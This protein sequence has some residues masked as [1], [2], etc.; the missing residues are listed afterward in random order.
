MMDIFCIQ[1]GKTLQGAVEISGSKN[2]SLPL[3]CCSLLTD[4][5]VTLTNVP[6]LRDVQTL[7]ELLMQH[8]VQVKH[9]VSAHQLILQAK[10]ITST[11][12]PYDIV[13]KMRASYYVLG[14]LLA[15]QGEV[16]L[17]LPGGCVIGARPMDLHL[18]AI[19]K[20]GAVV[21]LEKG[22]VFAQAP[23]GGLKGAKILFPK[24]SVGATIQAVMAA[25]LAKG[26]TVIE[27]AA[28]EP[29]VDDVANLLNKMG[30][31][32]S[33][34]GTATL[35]IEGVSSLKGAT[36][37][38]MTDRIEAPTYAIA[39]A[40]T[41]GRVELIHADLATAE[42]SFEKLHD[43]GVMVSATEKGILIDAQKA[44][45]K[46][47]DIE[48]EPY[49][50]FPT[51]VQA[52]F[53]ALMSLASG[54]SVISETIFENRFMHVSE[55]QRLGADIS[56]RDHSTAIVR[57]VKELT[58]AEVMAS[59]LRAGA[60]LILAGLAAKGETI[61]QRIYHIDRGYENLETKLQGLGAD[62][63]REK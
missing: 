37:Q 11:T 57:G 4:Q 47:L 60:S 28:R 12:A 50:G 21:H 9:D 7:S 30:A 56:I 25:V 3:M 41:H 1:G 5:L 33:G 40:I 36:H 23:A 44:E 45:I 51:D 10:E 18:M 2:A 58:G 62:I 38:V 46:G 16:H 26:T 52:Q 53:M 22:Y 34:I 48:T 31:Q 29:D 17:S 8:G 32:I 61:V 63:R 35:V 39:A 24:V 54:T 14:P 27:N 15:R 49:P 13:K 20:L 59:D 43:V 19:E 6:N 42:A 55:L